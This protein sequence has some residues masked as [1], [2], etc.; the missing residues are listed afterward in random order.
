[1]S[2]VK[3]ENY[4]VKT[5]SGVFQHFDG[6]FK[7]IH[8]KYCLFT[9][10]NGKELKCSLE[11][12]F[13]QWDNTFLLA[14]YVEEGTALYNDGSYVIK[15]EIIEEQIELFDLVN[16]K[17]GNVYSHDEGLASH[18]CTEFLGSSNTLLSAQTLR[19]LTMKDPIQENY[20]GCLR[21]YEE[22]E[23]GH[24]YFMTVDTSR[25]VGI[26]YSAFCVFDV[27][28]TPYRIVAVYKSNII[29]P[30]IYPEVLY[31]VGTQYNNAHILVEINDNGQQV[32]DM[33][34]WEYEYENVVFTST[35][36]RAGQVIGGGFSATTQRGVRTT[37][38]V[39]AVG[40]SNV[41]TLIENDQLLF[42]DYDLIY[43]FSC[44]VKTGSSFA[45]TQGD[46]DDLVMCTVL[47]AWATNQTFFKE[48]SETDIRKRLMQDKEKLLFDDTLPFGIIDDGIETAK[49]QEEINKSYPEFYS[50]GEDNKFSW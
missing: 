37:K 4:K 1:M 32:A 2:K 8:D 11:H 3:N 17:G 6:I 41:R 16:V 26:D 12:K 15:K 24:L 46:H 47:F 44:F 33:L 30:L 42:W 22:K 50:H 28:E 19:R 43:E 36:G 7:S 34:H 38:Q 18:N 29:D 39:K 9:F 21:I 20:N 5:P 35:R 25:G 13:L 31:T 23:P 45:A 27:T 48:M 10:S 49:N 14:E 40:C